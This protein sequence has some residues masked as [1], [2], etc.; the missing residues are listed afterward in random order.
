MDDRTCFSGALKFDDAVRLVKLQ[1]DALGENAGDGAMCNVR[2]ME[3]CAVEQLC[4]KFDCEVVNIICDHTGQISKL[5]AY[6]CAGS[7]RS[8]DA[9]VSFVESQRDCESNDSSVR[10][11]KIRINGALHTRKM[12]KA[13]ANFHAALSKTEVALPERTLVYSCVSGQPYASATEIRRLLVEQGL[14]DH[15]SSS[16]DTCR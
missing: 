1:A 14:P 9:L 4:K 6:G 16:K 3:R 13:K 12:E 15:R 8:I 7:V 2:G 5:N 10:A 11:A